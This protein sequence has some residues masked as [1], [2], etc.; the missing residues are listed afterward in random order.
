MLHVGLDLSRNRLDVHVLDDAGE[1]V[2]VTTAP[3]DRDGLAR[4]VGRFSGGPVAAVIESMNGARFVHDTLERHGWEAYADNALSASSSHISAG[5]HT[6][7][8][9]R[10]VA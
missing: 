6:V 5:P 8:K 10:V 9:G 2:E 4:K 7:V 1:T 3:P